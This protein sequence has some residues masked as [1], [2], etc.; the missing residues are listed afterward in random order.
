MSSP[1]HSTFLFADLAGYTALTEVHGDEH[2]VRTIE[3]Y[4]GEVRELLPGF[5]A[6][7]IKTIGD[8]LLIRISDAGQALS[9][10]LAIVSRIC[11]WHAFPAV[12]I[13]MHH[14]PA[15]ERG[16]DYFGR[17][18]NVAARVAA[19]AGAGEVLATA[20]TTAA[21][22]ASVTAV[23]LH[24]RG[25]AQLKG[26]DE[27]VRLYLA[28]RAGAE[29]AAGLPI[30]PVCQMG[31]EPSRSVGELAYEGNVYYFCSLACA[32]RFASEPARFAAGA[33]RR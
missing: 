10:G 9:L 17:T 33:K 28:T 26:I 11:A 1:D 2:A 13:G 4:F 21:A 3:E 20:E 14:G 25:T 24:D 7:E 22:G 23:E 32:G 16:G 19:L 27:P 15:I 6:E 12:R 8:A 30:D 31:V 18:V 5:G 29:T